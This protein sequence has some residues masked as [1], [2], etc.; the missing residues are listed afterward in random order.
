VNAGTAERMLLVTDNEM[1]AIHHARLAVKGPVL[2]IVERWL[3]R[4]GWFFE[5]LNAAPPKAPAGFQTVHYFECLQCGEEVLPE[6]AYL[7]KHDAPSDAGME[8]SR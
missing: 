3:R 5:K 7:H 8:G 1:W 2:D 6:H 4:N